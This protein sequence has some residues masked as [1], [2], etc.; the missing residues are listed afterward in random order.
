MLPVAPWEFPHPSHRRF[1]T[2]FAPS[3]QTPTPGTQT[4]A[5]R[6]RDGRSKLVTAS[7]TLCLSVT[8]PVRSSERS[9]APLS[10]PR[11]SGFPTN[12]QLASQQN[13]PVAGLPRRPLLAQS[14][15]LRTAN[16]LEE[17]NYYHYQFP[18]SVS[19]QMSA[20]PK[21]SRVISETR[22][23]ALRSFRSCSHLL[24]C[25]FPNPTGTVQRPVFTRHQY[26]AQTP[27]IQKKSNSAHFA[28]PGIGKKTSSA[29]TRTPI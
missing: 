11:P 15:Y 2:R 4:S 10:H 27:T 13:S 7:S 8:S 28:L 26:P 23:P 20:T 1:P 3:F 24:S 12:G 29:T 6:N 22:S 19:N 16:R 5:R 14:V 25:Y 21:T 9:K 18:N 17:N